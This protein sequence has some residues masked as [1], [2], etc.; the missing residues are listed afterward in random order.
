MPVNVSPEYA[1][2]EKKFLDAIKDDEK[3]VALEEMIRNAPSHK[4]GENLRAQLRIRYKKL[5]EKIETRGKK[6]GGGI[7]PTIKKEDMQ[8]VVV[9][10]PNSG[11]SFL[12]KN[13]TGINSVVSEIPF[14]TKIPIQGMMDFEGAQIQIID[15]PP[16]PKEDKSLVNGADV[17]AIVF[18]KISQIKDSDDFLERANG[19]KI[20]IYPKKD[21]LSE[22]DKRIFEAT[23]KS[24][25]KDKNFFIFSNLDFSS[26]DLNELKRNIFGLF[27][28]IR[29]YT[30]EPGKEPTG[31][32]V[33]LKVGATA[34]DVAEKILKGLS[35]R[36]KKARIWGPSSKFPG[37]IVGL[38]HILKDKDIVELQ[39][40]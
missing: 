32:P 33:I 22:N 28:I 30:K 34:E 4:G 1:K 8:A 3:I 35:K 27:P 39:I 38:G 18:D 24:K 29:V 17:I 6:S 10:F 20:Y 21:L 16:F 19:K 13:L 12:F 23:L 31:N 26:A 2:A 5:K 25:Y 36:I 9:G 11:K 37:Q 7:K 15:M 40:N 14:S